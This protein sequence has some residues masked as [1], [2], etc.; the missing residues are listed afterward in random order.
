MVIAAVVLGG[1]ILGAF[2]QTPT[3]EVFGGY[4]FAR[5]DQTN[6]P[7]GWNGAIAGNFSRN[8]GIVGDVSG[9]YYSQNVAVVQGTSVVNVNA[10]LN[11]LFYR[12]GPK[13]TLRTEDSHI[14]PFFQALVGGVRGTEDVGASGVNVSASS[15][16]FSWAVGGGMDIKVSPRIAVRLVQAEFNQLRFSGNSTD[17][18]RASTGLVFRF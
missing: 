16:G 6:V 13:F 11:L 10:N 5:A 2:A 17:G 14:E 9:H 4:S 7:K 12:F 3:V 15:N 1:G 18:L 8:L